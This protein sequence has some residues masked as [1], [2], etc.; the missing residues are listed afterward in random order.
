MSVT[1]YRDISHMPRV[2]TDTGA[3]I[4][5]RIAAAWDRAHLFGRLP[6]PKGVQ[7]FRSITEAQAARAADQR[8]RLAT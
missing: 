7:R 6:L 8:R 1:R 4:D 5:A 3:P 2:P